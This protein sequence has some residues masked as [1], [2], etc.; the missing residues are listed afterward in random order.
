MK[1][2][3]IGECRR[4]NSNAAGVFG[5]NCGDCKGL[6]VLEHDDTEDNEDNGGLYNS[7]PPSSLDS[8]SL[9]FSFR[10]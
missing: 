4:D 3:L 5:N 8:A 10:C 2:L 1:N 6:D 9:I 7:S